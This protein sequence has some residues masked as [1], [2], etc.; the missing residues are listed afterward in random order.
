MTLLGYDAVLFDL[1]G[2]LLNTTP[3][4]L[5][6]FRHTLDHYCPG[7][8]GE[9]EILACL[10]EPLLEQMARFGGEEQA[11][12]MVATYR[13]H[14]IAHHDEMVLAFPGVLD[15]LRLLHQKGIRLGVV[16][17]KYRRTVEMGL[18]LCGLT[19]FMEVV[20]CLG[21][22]E[23]AKPHPAPIQLAL[24]H[25]GVAPERALMVGDSRFDLLAAQRAGTVSVGVA[26]THHGKESLLPYH[27]DHLID[28]MAELLP[29]LGIEAEESSVDQVNG[30]RS[31]G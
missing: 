26:W 20:V 21:E 23:E 7:E 14:N 3:L 11:E 30:S 15:T 8:Y 6:S 4:I 27:P 22:A 16:T 28:T 10:G 1:D 31:H 29:I 12:E 24:K 25:L 2:T 17:N 5:S 9:D 18:S 13:Q 19:P